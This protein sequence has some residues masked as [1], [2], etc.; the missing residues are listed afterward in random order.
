MWSHH[1]VSSA[2]DK[3]QNLNHRKAHT[4]D[5][6][7]KYKTEICRNWENGYC[8]HEDR[9]SFAHGRGELK[10]KEHIPP[11]YRTKNC[12][13]FFKLGFCRYGQRCQFSHQVQTAP[14]TPMTSRRSSTNPKRLPIF[15]KLENNLI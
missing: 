7:V 9:C 15:V 1:M 8:P 13:H 2:F 11:N 10:T 12:L 5:F 3:K 14:N 6:K 4:S